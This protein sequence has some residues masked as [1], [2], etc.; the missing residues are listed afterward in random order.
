VLI[1]PELP[2]RLTTSLKMKPRVNQIDLPSI[3]APANFD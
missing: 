2:P 1:S 3:K